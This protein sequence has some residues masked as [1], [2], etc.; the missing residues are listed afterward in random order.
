M[1]A[2]PSLGSFT[3]VPADAIAALRMLPEIAENTRAMK[4]HTA[5]LTRVADALDRVAG[6]TGALPT[7]G[8][9]IE[10]IGKTVKS[11]DGVDDRVA[12]IEAAMP[13]LVEVQRHLAALPETMG[14]LDKGIAGLD[15]GIGGL[16]KGI[17]RLDKGIG[18]LSELMERILTGLDGMNA[19]VETLQGAVGPLASLA[20]RVP[21]RKK[22]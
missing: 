20:G 6:Y 19:S 1:A 21:G 16:D 5:A 4:E 3:G 14:R 18:G 22:G 9:E 2:L 10:Q 13:V 15:K 17:K 12:A 8:E 11:L 7:M